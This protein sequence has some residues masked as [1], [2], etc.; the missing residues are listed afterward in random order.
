MSGTNLIEIQRE[1]PKIR[2]PHWTDDDLPTRINFLRS[3]K[4]RCIISVNFHFMP[5]KYYGKI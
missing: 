4:M 3:I 2:H 5:M 1:A